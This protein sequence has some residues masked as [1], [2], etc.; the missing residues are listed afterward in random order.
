M[1]IA[2]GKHRQACAIRF[3]VASS[4]NKE[5]R[6]DGVPSP[7]FPST[8]ESGRSQTS[9]RP[10]RLRSTELHIPNTSHFSG[11]E[12]PRFLYFSSYLPFSHFILYFLTFLSLLSA[13]ILLPSPFYF[14]SFKTFVV[15]SNDFLLLP[16]R[17]LLR[18]LFAIPSC[19]PRYF[20]SH[21][22]LFSSFKFQTF[23]CRHAVAHDRPR[24]EFV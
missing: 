14:Q 18:I 5:H 19:S 1:P 8:L 16:H 24:S 10:G 22:T 4:G 6:V 15:A 9:L 11:F 20:H 23:L 3:V 13:I 17:R 7:V 12:N 21:I 2:H